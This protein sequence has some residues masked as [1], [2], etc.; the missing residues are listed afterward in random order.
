MVNAEIE[1]IQLLLNNA[2]LLILN[3]RNF[4]VLSGQ[5]NGNK[6]LTCYIVKDVVMARFECWSALKVVQLSFN[7]LT[8][9]LAQ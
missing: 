2:M 9:S 6:L 8:S 4:L 1:L 5:N 3:L 7:I